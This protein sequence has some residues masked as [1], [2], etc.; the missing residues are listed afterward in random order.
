[1]KLDKIQ[2]FRGSYTDGTAHFEGARS[3]LEQLYSAPRNDTTP[4]VFVTWGLGTGHTIHWTTSDKNYHPSTHK[5]A[6]YSPSLMKGISRLI[7]SRPVDHTHEILVDIPP[8][9]ADQDIVLELDT[10]NGWTQSLKGPL[11]FWLILN[12]NMWMNPS[13]S[14][15]I[16]QDIYRYFFAQ[17]VLPKT[18]TGELPKPMAMVFSGGQ[19]DNF[20]IAEILRETLEIEGINSVGGF[21][22]GVHCGNVRLSYPKSH[23]DCNFPKPASSLKEKDF[24]YPLTC[25]KNMLHNFLKSNSLID[26]ATG[27]KKIKVTLVYHIGMIRNWKM[28]V[29]DQFDTLNK[30]GTLDTSDQLL[31]TYS[32]GDMKMVRDFI[33]QLLGDQ[34]KHKLKK[35]VESTTEPWEVPAVNMMVDHC[36]G[37]SA[38]NDE[39]I[40]YFHNKGVSKWSRDWKDKLFEP[41][42]Y[43]FS[44]YWRK[45]IEY[46]TIER[47]YLCLEKLLLEKF[48]SCGPNWNRRSETYGDHYSGNMWAATCDHINHLEPLTTNNTSYT[49]AEMW[50]ESWDKSIPA[51]ITI[52]AYNLYE[53]L[54]LPKEYSGVQQ[55]RKRS[56]HN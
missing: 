37:S 29:S 7:S 28:V 42:T 35:V 51:K 52:G 18:W 24:P 47:P 46:F 30:C 41:Y 17:Q 38:P 6:S 11:P 15:K 56:Q 8:S 54:I 44:L 21:V 31:I 48:T 50:V 10:G 49:T 45:Y 22:G 14:H 53:H 5:T 12:G 13:I 23:V 26:E 9:I 39:V 3:R 16:M 1:M 43:A 32:N 19:Q 27:E 36:N 25:D 40:F 34:N 55:K 20:G 4:F 33:Y 2:S